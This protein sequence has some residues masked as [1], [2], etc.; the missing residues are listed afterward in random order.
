[1]CVFL[2]PDGGFIPQTHMANTEP[3]LPFPQHQGLRT[4]VPFWGGF[5]LRI[6]HGV[7]IWFVLNIQNG[8]HLTARLGQANLL[9]GS[10][11][12]SKCT[13]QHITSFSRA[14]VGNILSGVLSAR[15][16]PPMNIRN[17]AIDPQISVDKRLLMPPYFQQ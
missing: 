16:L 11:F 15:N 17:L 5:L 10:C 7:L 3:A 13:A 6:L 14:I 4:Q 9:E 12:D 1:M 2:C 8:H